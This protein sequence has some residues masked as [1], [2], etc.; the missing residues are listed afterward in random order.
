MTTNT[1]IVILGSSGQDGQTN[2][3]PPGKNK[4]GSP[5]TQGTSSKHGCSGQVQAGPGLTGIGGQPG[6]DGQDG[7]MPS[8][9]TFDLGEITGTVPFSFTPARGG[10]GGAGQG[11]G[12]GGDGGSGAGKSGNCGALPQG[13]GGTGGKGG[14]GGNAGNGGNAPD[15]LITYTGSTIPNIDYP[16]PAELSDLLTG[17]KGGAGGVGGAGGAG[18]PK[19]GAGGTGAVGTSGQTGKYKSYSIRQKS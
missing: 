11:G 16:T 2:P 17:G 9:A 18:S 19:G 13:D 4:D 7:Q 10:N 12:A 14:D 8:V 15:I 5:A 6:G 3:N 1:G